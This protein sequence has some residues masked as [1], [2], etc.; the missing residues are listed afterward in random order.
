MN[1][2]PISILESIPKYSEDLKLDL[3]SPRDRFL[4]FLASILFAKRISSSIA[5]NTFKLF[6]KYG[7]TS[8]DKIIEAGWNRIVDILDEGG[9]TRYDFS[10]VS[11]LLEVMKKLINEY[12]GSVDK[13]H[14]LSKDSRD[15]KSRLMEFKGIGPTAVNI[16]LRELRGIW[17]K[18]DPKISKYAAMVGKLIGLDNENIKRY[19]SPL[20]KIY[21]NYCKKKNCRICPL[22]NYCKEKEIK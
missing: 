14:E 15:L 3:T 10:T 9:Y 20:V 2:N 4:W 1:N 21:I 7:L 11:N 8:P 13:I 6:V 5:M 19:E 12:N 22:K 17:S 16:F 18:A